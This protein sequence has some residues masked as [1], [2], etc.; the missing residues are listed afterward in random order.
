MFLLELEGLEEVN[1]LSFFS[2][3]SLL[4]VKLNSVEDRNR[5]FIR[6]FKNVNVAFIITS[7]HSGY[8][9]FS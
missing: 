3:S 1:L 8:T 6:N 2:P 7:C 5:F 4:V 9:A